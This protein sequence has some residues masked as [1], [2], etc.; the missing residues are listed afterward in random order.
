MDGDRF[1][2]WTKAAGRQQTR[3][4][5][6]RLLA[7]AIGAGGA[8]P[9]LESAARS[10]KKKTHCRGGKTLCDGKCVNLDTDGRHCGNC[11]ANCTGICCAG[12]CVFPLTD[13]DH[14]GDCK[15]QC[16]GLDAAC[17]NGK[18][19]KPC[20]AGQTR[21]RPRGGV[22]YCA[23][24]SSDPKNCRTCGHVCAVN[25]VCR[26]GQGGQGI[27]C[28]CDGPY[29]RTNRGERCCPAVNGVC[30]ND[31]RCCRSGEICQPGDK[32]CP[33]GTYLCSDGATCCPEGTACNGGL[34]ESSGAGGPG[35]ARNRTRSVAAQPQL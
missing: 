10:R 4:G 31:G 8:A 9:L 29:C 33:E 21:C 34:C 24:L 11:D 23:D 6:V 15:T 18:C 26:A 20:P 1:D 32:C 13:P 14:C 3:R 12:V 19:A 16:D 35:G 30:C 17:V 25:E 27:I 5:M 28:S 2:Q 7:G 22:A